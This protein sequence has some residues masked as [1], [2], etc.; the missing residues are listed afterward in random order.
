ME[1]AT[2]PALPVDQPAGPAANMSVDISVVVPL[3]GCT[4]FIEELCRR[5]RTTL[6]RITDRY[7]IILV[8]DCGPDDAWPVIQAQAS[9]MPEIRA[10]RLSRNFGQ[11]AAIGAGLSVSCGAWIAVL[12]GDLQDP[13]EEIARLYEQVGEHGTWGW[14]SSLPAGAGDPRP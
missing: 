4:P 1:P 8:D 11:H 10:M 14:T 12:D 3:Y 5:L 9:R 13:P 2:N 6:S 7:E